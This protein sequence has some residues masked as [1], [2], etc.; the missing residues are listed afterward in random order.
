MTGPRALD[1]NELFVVI[2]DGMPEIANFGRFLN[3]VREWNMRP[4]HSSKS[5]LTLEEMFKQCPRIYV[6]KSGSGD[7]T[8]LCYNVAEIPYSGDLPDCDWITNGLAPSSG[9]TEKRHLV[10][11]WMG[12]EGLGA[13]LGAYD[14]WVKK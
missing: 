9:M 3:I 2:F 12:G 7:L 8:E 11:V 13:I 14:L 6:D 4:I 1:H 5:G 10:R